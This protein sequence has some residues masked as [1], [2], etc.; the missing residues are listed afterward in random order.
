MGAVFGMFA[1]FYFWFHILTG[2]HYSSVLSKIHFW[3]F[4][5]GV[6]FTFFS[7]AFFRVGWNAT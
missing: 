1:G 2:C 4:F 6:N 3:L 5:T 7:N